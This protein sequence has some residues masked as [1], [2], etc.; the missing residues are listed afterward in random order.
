MKEYLIRQREE[1]YFRATTSLSRKYIITGKECY[2]IAY[3]PCS[4]Y[5]ILADIEEYAY[6]SHICS[7]QNDKKINYN[8]NRIRE[9]GCIYWDNGKWSISWMIYRLNTS[10]VTLYLIIIAA[11]IALT[12]YF[13]I[14][15]N[16]FPIFYLSSSEMS[17]PKPVPIITNVSIFPSQIPIGKNFKLFVSATN[18]GDTADVQTVSIA[19]PNISAVN[20]NSIT[21]Y[22]NTSKDTIKLTVL[23]QNF[24]QQPLFISVGDTNGASYSGGGVTTTANYPLIEFYSR[25]WKSNL[26]YQSEIEIGSPSKFVGKF[27]IFVKSVALPH[28]TP[29]SHYP[30]TGITDSQNELVSVY[31]V[32][33]G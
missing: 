3:P 29:I 25:P 20:K 15:L 5:M 33:V 23:K 27:V 6:E 18:E 22:N 14:S 26:N 1:K 21:D 12:A 7:D 2:G 28:T 10:K 19:F 13:A 8:Q 31:Y 16:Y 4:S 24:T 17:K 11:V 32:K 30:Y 9:Y